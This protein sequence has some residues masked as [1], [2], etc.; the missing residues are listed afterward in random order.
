LKASSCMTSS[1]YLCDLW[2]DSHSVM[3]EYSWCSFS[4]G[5]QLPWVLVVWLSPV[6]VLLILLSECLRLVLCC[7]GF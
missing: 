6:V 5:F 2:V 4:G 7:V 1:L 3:C